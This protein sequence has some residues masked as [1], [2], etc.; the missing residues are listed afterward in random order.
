ML[1]KDELGLPVS[2]F[3]A[4]FYFYFYL[5]YDLLKCVYKFEI[6]S[7]IRMWSIDFSYNLIYQNNGNIISICFLLYC[8]T[9]YILHENVYI[10]IKSNRFAYLSVKTLRIA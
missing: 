5:I 1:I 7:T 8:I 10:Q 4:N 3:S 9:F 6:D 2:N